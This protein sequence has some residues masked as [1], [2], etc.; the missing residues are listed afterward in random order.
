MI[1]PPSTT[2]SSTWSRLTHPAI[3]RL[4]AKAGEE[5][6]MQV[7]RVLGEG[8]KREAETVLEVKRIVGVEVE[9]VLGEEDE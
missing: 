1:W 7:E 5:V 4:L 3:T 6:K 9:R 8:K 2:F